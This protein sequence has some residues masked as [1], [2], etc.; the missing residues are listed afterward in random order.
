MRSIKLWNF[1]SVAWTVLKRKISLEILQ[2][3]IELIIFKSHQ[4]VAA[5]QYI[6]IGASMVIS[7]MH[8]LNPLFWWE[9]IYL[10]AVIMMQFIA[11]NRLNCV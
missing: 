5:T 11:I 8:H 2:Q 4:K 6:I 10:L 1:E 7:I 9:V 3:K